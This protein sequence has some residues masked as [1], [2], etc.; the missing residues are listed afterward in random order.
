[1]EVRQYVGTGVRTPIS[2]VVGATAEA[3]Q[4]KQ[5]AVAVPFEEMLAAAS[6]TARAVDDKLLELAARLGLTVHETKTAHQLRMGSRS[7]V[8]FYPGWGDT[9]ALEANLN[10]LRR[11]GRVE[12]ANRVL[13]GFQS[14]SP[15]RSLTAK[16]PWID[17]SAVDGASWAVAAAT[18]EDELLPALR[19]ALED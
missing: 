13:E 17:G 14:L 12:Q 19:A 18:I 10:Q 6:P 7:V 2:R 11:A 15:T 16:Y 3:R 8:H 9:G 1:V 4:R 5:P